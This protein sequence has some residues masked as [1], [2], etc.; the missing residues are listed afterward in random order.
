MNSQDYYYSVEPIEK[1]VTEQEFYEFVGTYPRPLVR[2]CCGISEPPAISYNDFELADRWPYSVV[3]ST[4]AYSD[5]PDDYYY[6]AKEDRVYRIMSNYKEVFKS[7]TGNK[8]DD[9]KPKSK[10]EYTNCFVV[11]EKEPGWNVRAD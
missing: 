7:R 8:T 10:N 11:T 1:K 6:T 4:F 5:D 3:A 9:N 2:D